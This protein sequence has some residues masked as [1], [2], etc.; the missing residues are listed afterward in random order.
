MDN[1]ILQTVDS[2][3]TIYIAAAPVLDD[4]GKVIGSRE[5]EFMFGP[6][7]ADPA[8]DGMMILS[9]LRGDGKTFSHR[10]RMPELNHPGPFSLVV[11]NWL[12][13]GMK[14]LAR[15]AEAEP[16]SQ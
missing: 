15:I 16:C 4:Q 13:E 7:E 10:K 11:S 2:G 3:G 8:D 6:I 1:G 5:V 12:Y 9:A 14:E